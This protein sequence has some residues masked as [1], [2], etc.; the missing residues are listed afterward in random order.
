MDY[1]EHL[2]FMSCWLLA[3]FWLYT[4][5]GMC[6]GGKASS[7]RI[8]K[9]GTSQ[10]CAVFDSILGPLS[11]YC[12]PHCFWATFSLCLISIL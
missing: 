10:D 5:H 1:D 4:R 7:Q 12:L 6:G 3:F 8:N 9:K 11:T 2:G